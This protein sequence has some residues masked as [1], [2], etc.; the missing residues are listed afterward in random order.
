M[1]H[2][3][4]RPCI[5]APPSA[6]PSQVQQLPRSKAHRTYRPY[7]RIL[8]SC[9][10][11]LILYTKTCWT[12]TE[13]SEGRTIGLRHQYR[14]R[15][16]N[17]GFLRFL[18]RLQS[19]PEEEEMED[20]CVLSTEVVGR[21][22]TKIGGRRI[23]VFCKY[24]ALFLIVTGVAVALEVSFWGVVSFVV[25]NMQMNYVFEVEEY[26]GVSLYLCV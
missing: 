5:T 9:R 14:K 26:A 24:L 7:R 19:I 20:V 13:N 25:G 15:R 6:R 4:P 17:G 16:A 2:H 21:R 18:P 3:E 10:S 1:D 23:T 8:P 22:R 12:I 11:H